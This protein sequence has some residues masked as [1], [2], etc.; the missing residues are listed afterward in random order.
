[1]R[2]NNLG[3][4]YEG[5]DINHPP[6]FKGEKIELWKFKMTTFLEYRDIDIL[7]VIEIGIPSLLDASGKF[8]LRNTW[9]DE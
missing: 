9:S 7:K 1:M 8:L 5:Q 3:L 2:G 6:L 4:F